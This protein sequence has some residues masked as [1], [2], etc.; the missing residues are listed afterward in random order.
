M[1]VRD[2][3]RI[4]NFVPCLMFMRL[5]ITIPL[6]VWNLLVTSCSFVFYFL[7]VVLDIFGGIVFLA[8]SEVQVRLKEKER[9]WLWYMRI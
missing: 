7:Q 6:S 3:Q 9:A 4:F 2:S 5:I 1:L 8:L